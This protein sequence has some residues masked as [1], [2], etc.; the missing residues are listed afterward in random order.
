MAVFVKTK[1]RGRVN[2]KKNTAY[3]RIPRSHFVVVCKK[4]GALDSG[5]CRRWESNPQGH[6]ARRILSPLRLPVSPL[7]PNNCGSLGKGPLI[8]NRIV[9]LGY[10]LTLS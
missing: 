9:Q 7:R 3:L 2:K 4:K 8:V 5:W 10:A 6:K 1:K